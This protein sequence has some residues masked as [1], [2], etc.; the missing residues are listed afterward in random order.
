[1]DLLNDL[2]NQ[3]DDICETYDVYKVETI[4][5]AYL[6]SSGV[7]EPNEAHAAEICKMGL[8]L[9]RKVVPFEVTHK[10]GYRI[11]GRVDMRFTLLFVLQFGASS[12]STNARECLSRVRRA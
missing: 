1:V 6:V 10:P 2:Y 7:P 3:F 12:A 8:E 11:R 9:L 5:D 4:G